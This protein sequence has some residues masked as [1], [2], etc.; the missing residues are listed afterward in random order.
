MIKILPLILL[1]FLIAGC[2]SDSDINEPD[3]GLPP[4]VPAGLRITFA[5]DGEIVLRWNP[6]IEPDFSHYTIYRSIDSLN[7]NSIAVLNTEYF[8]D[9]S[10]EYSV[11]YFYKISAADNAGRES[12]LSDEVSAVPV[13][14][15]PPAKPQNLNINGRN[16][17][18]SLSVFLRWY[19]GF[20]SDVTGYNIYRSDEITFETDSSTFTG[21]TSINNFTDT[22]GLTLYK[23]YYYIIRG[24]DKGGLIG[25]ESDIVSDQILGIP[26]IIFPAKGDNVEL[27][28]H[29]IIG[30][31]PVPA[32]Y[33][34]V[35]QSN[36]F[37]G[38]IWSTE[39]VSGKV[40]DT[41]MIRFNPSDIE[42]NKRY[43]WRVA[44]STLPGEPNS[45]SEL[46]DFIIKP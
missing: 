24:V 14:F 38:E 39:I 42:V 10:L 43:F 21:F 30:A 12:E 35:V 8:L 44:A 15:Y 13:N 45:I 36:E 32:A 1:L 11:K 28:S 23:D 4:G 7:Y 37:F 18:D 20:E 9:D 34:I 29:F 26:E 25:E 19:P 2:R 46:Y 33:K 5:N 22:S 17:Q 40:N 3:D 41:L 16:L 6:N 27:F 31:L